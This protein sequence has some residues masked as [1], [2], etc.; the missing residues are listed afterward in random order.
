MMAVPAVAA[1]DMHSQIAAILAQIS[2]LQNQIAQMNWGSASSMVAAVGTTASGDPCVNLSY[3][4]AQDDDDASKGGEVTEL[5]EFLVA[6]RDLTMPT[7]VAMGFFGPA[8]E[9]AVQKY[10]A[11]KGIVSSGTPDSSGYGTVGTRTRASMSCTP[12]STTGGGST[13]TGS[14]TPSNAQFVVSAFSGAA[15]LTVQFTAKQATNATDYSVDFG[16]GTSDATLERATCATGVTACGYKT[17]HTY[18]S[19]GT[20]T[21]KLLRRDTGTTLADGCDSEYCR[22]ILG[23]ANSSVTTVAGQAKITVGGNASSTVIGPSN[24]GTNVSLSDR[25]KIELLY[26]GYLGR[27]GD[28]AGVNYWVAQLNAGTSLA[29]IAQS[30]GLSSESK[31]RNPYLNAPGIASPEP[32]VDAVYMRLFNREPDA[33][34]KAYWVAALKERGNDTLA[35]ARIILDI[36]SGATQTDM[37]TMLGKIQ[38]AGNNLTNQSGT[39]STTAIFV[40]FTGG[41]FVATA[42]FQSNDC[43]TGGFRIN[44]GDG[45]S[46]P[47]TPSASAC[48]TG[49]PIASARVNYGTTHTYAAAGTYTVRLYKVRSGGDAL[50]SSSVFI[51]TR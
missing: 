13:T 42:S 31:T 37:R 15:P 49:T 38:A 26:I 27:S 41:T 39:V 11:R 43:G 44:W 29:Q 22:I 35:I 17:S 16:D 40:N 5:Q 34:G 3:N 33:A 18:N 45:Q 4:L 48:P 7:G 28:A 47:I 25:E 21:A 50:L 9:R 10:Q 32:F 36:Q 24:S 2:A 6:T 23:I 46:S 8:T 51:A 19:N 14:S 12:G 1:A 30:I 20:Y